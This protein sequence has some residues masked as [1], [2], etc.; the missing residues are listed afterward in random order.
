M[1]CA[2]D[3]ADKNPQKLWVFMS[4]YPLI[5]SKVHSFTVKA[6]CHE[7]GNAQHGFSPGS[8]DQL[9]TEL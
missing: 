7:A 6:R 1:I 5:P 2:R 8:S 3:D 9:H 4:A